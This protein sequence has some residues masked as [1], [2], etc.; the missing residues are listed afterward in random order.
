MSQIFQAG[1]FYT[2]SSI[3]SA[4]KSEYLGSLKTSV[5]SLRLTFALPGQLVPYS[6]QLDNTSSFG[7][8]SLL[9]VMGSK[10]EKW[11]AEEHSKKSS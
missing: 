1:V 9:S 2:F 10:G 11:Y 6:A 8:L 4:C 3:P 5:D 7:P